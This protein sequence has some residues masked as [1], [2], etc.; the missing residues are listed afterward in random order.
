MTISDMT[1]RKPT[2]L[3]VDDDEAIR[4]IARSMLG[5]SEFSVEEAADGLYAL[6]FLTERKPDL[7]VLDFM[8]PGMDGIS[9]CS[10]LRKMSGGSVS[11]SL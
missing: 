4:D 7:M 9:V 1:F 3:V 5:L 8:L 10:E 6:S 2:V 11:P